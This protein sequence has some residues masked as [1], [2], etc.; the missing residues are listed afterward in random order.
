[1]PY[2][3]TKMSIPLSAE[4]EQRLKERLG[5]AISVIP[6]KSEEWLML[7]FE[8]QC[9]MYFQGNNDTPTAF[10]E[11]KLF[12]ESTKEAYVQMTKEVTAIFEE[13]LSI[14]PSRIYIK[15]SPGDD[16]GWNG[17]NF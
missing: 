14:A 7:N 13:E 1:M 11:I 12:R 10:V 15:Y 5:K 9:R 17:G 2:I 8:D 16:W 4:K 3:E 6:G